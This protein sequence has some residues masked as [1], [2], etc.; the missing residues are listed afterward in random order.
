MPVIEIATV[1]A[2]LSYISNQLVDLVKLEAGHSLNRLITWVVTAAVAVLGA[3]GLV[4]VGL[5]PADSVQL[6]LIGVFPATGAWYQIDSRKKT[7]GQDA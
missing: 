5:I 6:I 2:A 7:G 4:A 1:I 3:Y